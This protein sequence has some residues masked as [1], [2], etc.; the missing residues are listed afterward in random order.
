MS[1]SQTICWTIALCEVAAIFAARYPTLPISQI[2]IGHLVFSGSAD[3]I[4]PTYLFFLGAFMIT[5]GGCIRYSCFRALGRLFTFEMSIRDEHE[6]ITDG[7]YSV[8]RH[9]SYTGALLTLIGIIC[10]HSSPVRIL[11]ISLKTFVLH[12][13][14]RSGFLDHRIWGLRN[15]VGPDCCFAVLCLHF[16]INGWLVVAYVE[17]R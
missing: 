16:Y 15:Q 8:V 9:P 4:R 2:I 11:C 17:G 3:S 7:P 12:F 5:L 6:L 13:F 1:L 14:N 10:W